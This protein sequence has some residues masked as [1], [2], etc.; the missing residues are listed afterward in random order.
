MLVVHLSE[1]I[2]STY[3]LVINT[4]KFFGIVEVMGEE[5]VKKGEGL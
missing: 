1:I 5:M 2:K 3:I 4:I